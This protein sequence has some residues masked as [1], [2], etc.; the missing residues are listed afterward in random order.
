MS[1]LPEL[2]IRFQPIIHFSFRFLTTDEGLPNFPYLKKKT[3]YGHEVQARENDW[4][5]RYGKVW[6]M[7]LS[8]YGT[9]EFD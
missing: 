9:G 5:R 2:H 7:V 1:P 4:Q 8:D 6:D 3:G